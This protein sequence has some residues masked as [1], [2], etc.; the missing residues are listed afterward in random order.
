MASPFDRLV[1]SP[2]LVGRKSYL[3]SLDHALEDVVKRTGRTV[4][5]AGEAGIGKSRLVAEARARADE[6][7]FLGLEGHCFE[8]DR[9]LS[10]AP[11]LDLLRTRLASQSPEEVTHELGPSAPELVPLLPELATLLPGLP[12][13]RLLAPEQEKR[14]GVDRRGLTVPGRFERTTCP[15]TDAPCPTPSGTRNLIGLVTRR[16]SRARPEAASGTLRDGRH[17]RVRCRPG[18][19]LRFTSDAIFVPIESVGVGIGTSWRTVKPL[20]PT[21]GQSRSGGA[22]LMQ[23]SG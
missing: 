12:A 11:L 8:P 22:G 3:E 21:S 5:I 17:G 16:R 6:L 9:S 1:L 23:K 2:V 19:G 18:R 14:R 20:R 7:G 10:Y 15:Q 13:L 4:L